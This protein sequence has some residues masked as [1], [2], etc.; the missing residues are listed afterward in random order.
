[1]P[2]KPTD[3]AKIP[4][5]A[6]QETDPFRALIRYWLDYCRSDGLSERSIA[7][8]QSKAFKFWWFW[9]EYTD[10]GKTLGNH[11]KFVTTSEARQFA[12][13]LR[14]KCSTRWGVKI[15]P[16]KE[17]LAPATIASFGRTVKI[18]FNWL[19]MMGH[20]PHTPFNRTVK[21]YNRQKTDK[22]IKVVA[23]EDLTKILKALTQPERLATFTGKRDLAMFE[24]LLDSGIRLGEMLNL[25]RADIDLKNYR[26]VV[27]GKT[28]KRYA[29][30]SDSC[31]NAILGYLD[32]LSNLQ[33]D[34]P[35]FQTV[36][37]NQMTESGFHS[38]VR[39]VKEL[40]GVKF[41]AHKL[42]HTFATLMAAQGTNVFDLKEL[43]GHSSITTT[44]IYVKGNADRLG[45]V[46]RAKS[47]LTILQGRE[48]TPSEIKKKR[49]GR[50]PHSRY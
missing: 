8:Y 50:P 46:H 1:M 18:F 14:G 47:P 6:T 27:S 4:S 30:F 34:A 28:G 49:R 43:L 23:T 25:K 12:S 44:E 26:C 40:S 13:Y 39:R 35:L 16:G 42:R 31:R 9:N 5:K 24:L 7:D 21:F 37:G 22:V 11:P 17:Y 29:M 45:E 33:P 3:I 38:L 48:D 41:H 32:K 10:F 15:R 36:D 19:E 20:I 2:D